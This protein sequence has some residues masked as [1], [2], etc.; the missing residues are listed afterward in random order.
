MVKNQPANVGNTGS[1]PGLGKSRILGATASMLHDYRSPCSTTR[2]AA[3]MRSP[4]TITSE[5]P[6]VQLKKAH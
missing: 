6:L 5:Y 2:E 4:Y 3:T 1:I